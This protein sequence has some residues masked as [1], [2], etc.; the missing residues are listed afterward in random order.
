MIV[1]AGIGA[2]VLLAAL[3][4]A[5][6]ALACRRLMRRHAD[7]RVENAL[8]RAPYLWGLIPASLLLLLAN[9][10]AV[11]VRK[12]H[13]ALYWGFPLW[14]DYSVMQIQWGI[15]T[16]IF[17]FTF[18][19]VSTLALRTAH[20]ERH[21]LLLA[22]V[23]LVAAIQVM[24]WNYTRPIA[25]QLRDE[26]SPAGMVSQT[27]PVS[28]AAASGATI[29]RSFGI[30]KSERDVAA[31]YGTS[32]LGTS[33]AQVVYG[34]ARLGIASRKRDLPDRDPARLAPPAMIFVDNPFSGPESH[35]VAFLGMEGGKAKIWD[36]LTGLGRFPA[37]VL[38]SFWKGHG[39]EFD[40]PGRR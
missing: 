18:G 28:C 32:I 7:L 8:A 5:L 12:S 22:S 9:A 15:L 33:A 11:V 14:L 27:S 26:V 36:P 40:P 24:Q 37:P 16:G 3:L 17:A 34:N 25:G 30:A 20:R 1:F 4:A 19:L 21:K 10:V 38:A 2:N 6:G 23:L 13:P 35:A 31:L 29:L 39:V